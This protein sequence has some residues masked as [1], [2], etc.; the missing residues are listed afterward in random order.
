ML[1]L[2]WPAERQTTPTQ[3]EAMTRVQALEVKAARADRLERELLSARQELASIK[4]RQ[5]Q[6]D[7]KANAWD[8]LMMSVSMTLQD[9]PVTEYNNQ[10]RHILQKTVLNWVDALDRAGVPAGGLRW[11]LN[12]SNE[13]AVRVLTHVNESRVMHTT[14]LGRANRLVVG[15][16][17]KH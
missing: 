1:S 14:W 6:N 3:A 5:R 15:Q 16:Q 4:L 2:I 17:H 13:H 8:R 12:A 11:F 9:L 10:T 7:E